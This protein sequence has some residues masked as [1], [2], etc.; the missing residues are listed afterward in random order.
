MTS[1][2]SPLPPP[3]QSAGLSAAV[4]FAQILFTDFEAAALEKIQ[5]ILSENVS[6]RKSTSSTASD[7]PAAPR[8][9]NR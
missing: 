4:H 9:G 5:L 1:S 8:E 7:R 3:M 2:P 6:P